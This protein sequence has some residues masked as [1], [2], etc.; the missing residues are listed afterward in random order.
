MGLLAYSPLAMGLLTVSCHLPP[1][2]VCLI[3]HMAAVLPVAACSCMGSW[4][5]RPVVLWVVLQG[6]YL[7][8]GGPPEARLNRYRGR[9]AEAEARYGLK[10]NTLAAVR[11]YLRLA[12]DAGLSPT[13]LA[14]R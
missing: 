8:G 12:C 6:K 2:V 10:A 14:L 7:E 9:Y 1:H 3:R 13:E 11:A 5:R 4:H